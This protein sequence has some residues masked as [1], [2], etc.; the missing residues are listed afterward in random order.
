MSK[1]TINKGYA[2]GQTKMSRLPGRGRTLR[3]PR[4]SSGSEIKMFVFSVCSKKNCCSQN[5][6]MVVFHQAN[7]ALCSEPGEPFHGK[8]A[9]NS[10]KVS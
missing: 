3:I 8:G 6:D 4:G 7:L 9:A 2:V 1:R 10:K 5:Q